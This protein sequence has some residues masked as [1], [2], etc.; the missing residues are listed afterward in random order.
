M[1]AEQVLV[2][3]HHPGTDRRR[4]WSDK[5]DL[6]AGGAL[7]VELAGRRR[8][9]LTEPSRLTRNRTVV[10]VDP[11]PTGDDVLDEALRRIAARR[12]ARAQVVL[13]TI[14]KGV[15]GRLLERLAGQGVLRS[16]RRKLLGIVPVRVWPAVD[17][18][19]TEELTRGLRH[20]LVD[21][22]P[23]TPHEAAL[24]SLLHTV[25]GT[26]KVLGGTG[27]DRRELERRAKAITGGDAAADVVHQALKAAAF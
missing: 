14:A 19:H 11:A 4:I 9:E 25:G 8:I 27:L 17:V 3:L 5:V 12:S 16:E 22:R 13:S 26:A 15:R 6:A 24:I 21:Q 7:L 18:R 23:P 1:L 2:L 10:L 20:V